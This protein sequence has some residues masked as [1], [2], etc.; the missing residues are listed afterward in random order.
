M[1]QL[2]TY[3]VAGHAFAIEAQPEQFSVLSNYT[4]FIT[5]EKGVTHMFILQL[6]DDLLPSVEGLEH[7]HTE[8]PEAGMPRIEMYRSSDE[9]LFRMAYTQQGEVMCA[10]RCSA[11]W[12]TI[13]LYTHPEAVRFTVDNA[14]MLAFASC[15]LPNRTL[16]FH[17]SV[18]MCDGRGY[19][20]LGRSGTGKS[21]HSQLWLQ[22][23][24]QAQLLNDDNPVVRV[25]PDDS[26][27]VY[28]SPWSGKTPCYRNQDLPVGALVQIVQAPHNAIEHLSMPQAYP[29]LLASVCGLKM[30]P[31]VMDRLYESIA[32]LL[33]RCPVYRLECLPNLEAAQLCAQ[34]CLS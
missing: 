25:L 9:W 14:A 12:R 16:L 18:T 23:F 27:R 33:A 5:D 22:A 30:Q 29:Y 24:P 28:G 11:D 3:S 19:L 8:A 1:K 20:F 13:S 10:F 34:T 32:Q 7:V 21:T 31:D 15:A 26:V 4:P 2:R 17:S 6:C